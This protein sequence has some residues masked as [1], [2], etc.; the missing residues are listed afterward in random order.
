MV[1]FIVKYYPRGGYVFY[2]DLTSAYYETDTCE[3]LKSGNIE[4]V[5]KYLSPENIRPIEDFWSLLIQKI[6]FKLKKI[7][8][9]CVTNIGPNF[10]VARSRSVP[11]RLEI[12]RAL[13]VD[14]L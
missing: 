3:H 7:I 4:F 8:Q 2:P 9:W 13:G 14:R 5:S 12:V 10:V 11:K 1:R 6:F